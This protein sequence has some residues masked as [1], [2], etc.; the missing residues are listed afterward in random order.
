MYDPITITSLGVFDDNA[1]GIAG[2]LRVY[3]YDLSD[4]SDP[5]ASQTISGSVDLLMGQ[6]RFK[7]ITPLTLD[8]GR[9]SVVAYGFGPNDQ[10]A[11]EE[12]SDIPLVTNDG[13]GSIVFVDSRFDLDDPITTFP[14]STTLGFFAC[15]GRP[16][17]CFGAGSFKYRTSEVNIG[18][19]I[20]PGSDLNPINMCSSGVIP[21]AIF[22]S[23]TFNVVDVD[24]STLR[25]GDGTPGGSAVKMVGR[26]RKK[27]CNT[28]D[29]DL[30]GHDDLVC[31]FVTIDL[32][33]AEGA[34][35]AMVL[36]TNTSTGDFTAT[37][38]VEITKFC[39]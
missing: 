32:N 3:I 39:E 20:K 25:L 21:V 12:V 34:T 5:L 37:D 24:A 28:E 8:P 1:D 18:I 6:F 17:A 11:N 19:D 22:G 26:A 14:L 35:E 36:G 13:G 9:Y 10:N 31:M 38:S 4:T 27:L 7:D 23:D 30:D 2:T 29:V 16:Q 33:L 15:S